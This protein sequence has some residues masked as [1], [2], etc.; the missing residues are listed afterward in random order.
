MKTKKE[1]FLRKNLGLGKMVLIEKWLES[2]K[3]KHY[4]IKTNGT[5]DVRGGVWLNNYEEEQ[6]PEYIQFGIVT[7]VFIIENSNITTL[8]GCPT[9]VGKSF[10]C[11]G[12]DKLKSLQYAPKKVGG[13]FDCNNCSSLISL[14][15]VPN[16]V[17]GSFNCSHCTNLTSL[18]GAPK[19][20][21]EHF[22]CS[23][24]SN[25]TSLSGAP[26]VVGKD[27]TCIECP[28][29]KSLKYSPVTV[30]GNFCCWY[31]G[32]SFTKDDV[33]NYCDANTIDV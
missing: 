6:L 29:L 32:K 3:I 30:G 18:S 15:G 10:Y 27:F 31:C 4:T 25:L 11:N 19:M 1:G 21:N 8:R 16:S 33:E 2:K 23:D 17:S 12:C 5:I 28:K 14:K 9:I 13:H 7:G 24:C 20:V 22:Y 26:Y